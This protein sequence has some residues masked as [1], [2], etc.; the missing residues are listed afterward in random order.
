MEK[1]HQEQLESE[2]P[3]LPRIADAALSMILLPAEGKPHQEHVLK[4]WVNFLGGLKQDYEI[5]VV[6][7]HE[8]PAWLETL[9][10]ANARVR[11]I[12]C[13][14]SG[15]GLFLRAGLAEARHPLVFYTAGSTDY[16]PADLRGL[17]KRVNEVHLVTGCR[18]GEPVPRWLGWLGLV[19]RVCLRV[20]MGYA[21]DSRAGW[22]GWNAQAYHWLIRLLF[23]VRIHDVNCPFTLLRRVILARIP[24]QSRGSF[25][26][27]EILAKANFL[28][29]LMDEVPI[30]G[31]PRQPV[32][33]RD[34]RSDLKRVFSHP[35]FGPATLPDGPCG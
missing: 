14:D 16:K 7:N 13:Q 32:A 5:L 34:V 9:R 6:D 8:V 4:Q 1:T 26:Q 15:A 24:I 29:C 21:A 31:R 2:P 27:A 35:D 17:L 11:T 12:G 25:V 22:L 3:A 28:G 20:V 33:W 19:W 30:A 23:G 18:A 10:G